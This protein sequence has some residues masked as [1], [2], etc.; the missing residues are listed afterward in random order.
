MPIGILF[1]A[2]FIIYLLFNGLWWRN[3][4]GWA[5]GW[6]GHMGLVMVL[7]FLLGWSSFGFILQGGRGSPF[8]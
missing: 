1:W 3:G 4:A 8:H 2:I 5:Y 6:G 7:I